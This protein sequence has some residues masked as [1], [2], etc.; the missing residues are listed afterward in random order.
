MDDGLV[1]PYALVT[2]ASRLNYTGT[3]TTS[4]SAV[5]FPLVP[6]SRL[7]FSGTPQYAYQLVGVSAYY[8]STVSYTMSAGVMSIDII[9]LSGGDDIALARGTYDFTLSAD[10]AYLIWRYVGNNTNSYTVRPTSG[11]TFEAVQS[12]GVVVPLVTNLSIG[13]KIT[14]RATLSA[15]LSSYRVSASYPASNHSNLASAGGSSSGFPTWYLAALY[16]V[17]FSTTEIPEDITILG[18]IVISLDRIWSDMTKG[19]SDVLV[20]IR[21]STSQVV[22]ALQ[23]ISGGQAATPEQSQHAQDVQGAVESSSQAIES[24][25]QAIASA[26]PRDDPTAAAPPPITNFVDTSLP[27][28]QGMEATFSDILSSPVILP[29]L[30]L[31]VALAT[32]KVVLYGG[33][34]S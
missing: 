15:D 8:T 17:D 3:L 6:P 13:S 28:V 21:S 34:G 7:N 33:V 16:D 10:D 4:T 23:G 19:F 29:V 24:A 25:N 5:S 12:D 2:T 1:S 32:V 18:E 20:A 22:S 11:L 14:V 30:L 27:E 31:V 26:A 9:R